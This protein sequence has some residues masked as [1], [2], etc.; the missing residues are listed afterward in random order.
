MATL[1]DFMLFNACEDAR[2]DS[3]SATGY[4]NS[5]GSWTGATTGYLHFETSQK[6]Q[7]QYWDSSANSETGSSSYWDEDSSSSEDD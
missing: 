5:I 2:E 3:S 7:K 1:E 6:Y 4:A